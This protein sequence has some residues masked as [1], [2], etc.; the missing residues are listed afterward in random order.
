MK[1]EIF[2]I[3]SERQHRPYIVWVHKTRPDLPLSFQFPHSSANS[4]KCRPEN[5]FK[6]L[7]EG[8]Y[9]SLRQDPDMSESKTDVGIGLPYFHRPGL[10]RLTQSLEAVSFALSPNRW[11]RFHPG[12]RSLCELISRPHQNIRPLAAIPS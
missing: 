2:Y 8:S 4:G 3:S 1:V 7:E 5:S 6:R 9:L 10:F 11:A 12:F